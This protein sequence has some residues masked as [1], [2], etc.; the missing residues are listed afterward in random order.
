M[1]KEIIGK[2]LKTLREEKN[3]TQ[4]QLSNEFSEV[5]YSDAQISKWET[6]KAVPNVDD[7][8]ILA[9]YFNVTVDEILNGS[10]YQEANFEDKYF[11]YNTKWMSR[12]KPD[13]LYNIREEQELLIETRF[14][15][16][17]KKIV[18]DG[19]SLSE[20]KEFDFLVN[21]FY[22]I[23]IPAIECIDKN[24]YRNSGVGGCAWVEDI[25]RSSCDC[26]IG[27]LADIKFEIY[28]QTAL[29]HNS[30]IEEKYW[31]AN[32]K[33]I[34]IKRQNIREDINDVIEDRENDLK[35]RLSTLDE[36]EKDI[37]LATL[38][39][40]NVVNTLASTS[41][42]GKELYEKKYGRKYDD[43]E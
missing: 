23:F 10:R 28:K 41:P 33:F 9:K 15:E 30:T 32:K 21:H 37:L 38:Q 27:D 4:I 25:D 24:A 11:I 5:Y 26:L 36:Y 2:F 3:L 29:M 12:Y 17:L 13:E 39:Q 31:E 42:K 14:K 16:L 6:G 22:Q 35:N 8:K 1:N 18:G 43:G 40:V 34:F 7:L 20:D 19:L